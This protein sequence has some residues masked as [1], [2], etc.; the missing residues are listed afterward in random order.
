[1]FSFAAS[2]IQIV[3]LAPVRYNTNELTL[4]KALIRLTTFGWFCG[5]MSVLVAPTTFLI[6]I[7]Y[8]ELR[9][10]LGRNV[11]KTPLL[12]GVFFSTKNAPGGRRIN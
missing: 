3:N 2:T 11:T 7:F 5:I 6:H 4:T 1:M 9:A 8:L 10:I 12:A